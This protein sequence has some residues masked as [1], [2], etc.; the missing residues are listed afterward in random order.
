MFRCQCLICL[1][2]SDLSSFLLYVGHSP[3]RGY[4]CTKFFCFQDRKIT[5]I[6]EAV[7]DV[8]PSKGLSYFT[9]FNCF[10]LVVIYFELFGLHIQLL[11]FWCPVTLGWVVI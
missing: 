1:I 2:L 10:I 11:T 7:D 4:E 9:L 5:G 3:L 6:Q 8:K